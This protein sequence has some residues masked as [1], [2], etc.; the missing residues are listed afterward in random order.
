MK[1]KFGVIFRQKNL[2]SGGLL[3]PPLCAECQ[4]RV[5]IGLSLRAPRVLLCDPR[6]EKSSQGSQ[7]SSQGSQKNR[8]YVKKLTYIYKKL[9]YIF[10]VLGVNFSLHEKEG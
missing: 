3:R 9:T 6:D 7:N 2:K 4:N 1:G 5:K 8:G 10:E